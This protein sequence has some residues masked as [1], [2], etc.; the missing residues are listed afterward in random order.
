MRQQWQR[1]LLT[2]GAFGILFVGA[3]AV[4]AAWEPTEPE[5]LGL[6]PGTPLIEIRDFGFNPSYCEV[7]RHIRVYF[8]NK[9]DKTQR[10]LSRNNRYGSNEPAQDTGDMAPGEIG[11]PWRIDYPGNFRFYLEGDETTEGTI[12]TPHRS[13]GTTN[14]S[15]AGPT[16]TPTN[17]PTP[18]PTPSATATPT[19]TPSA[20][21]D[22]EPT[23]NRL[24][25]PQLTR[26]VQR[27]Q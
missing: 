24:I 26:D 19:A 7:R 2:V 27:G 16:P 15:P 1:I 8:V 4:V 22:P 12:Y 17:T 25:L 9:T 23:P 11:K 5:D 14:C 20:T 10:V 13:L 21:P 3:G 18:S 6:D